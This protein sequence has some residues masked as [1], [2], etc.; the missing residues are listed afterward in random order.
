MTL[1]RDALLGK[2]DD[3]IVSFTSSIDEDRLIVNEV[4]EV[5]IAHVHHLRSEGLIPYEVGDKALKALRELLK[6]SDELFRFKVED[7]HEAVEVYLM[8]ALGVDAGW[9]P[10]G[11]SRN[12]HVAT[13]LRLKTKRL[14]VELIGEMLK[15]REVL[16]KKAC[17][18]LEIPLPLT[19]HLQSAQVSTVA[20]YLTYIE[21]MLSNYTSIIY[22][23]LDVFVDKSPLGAGAIAGTTVPLNRLELARLLGF[24]SLVNN[25]LLATGSRDFICVVASVI[26]SLAVSL[27]RIAEDFI[28]WG[29]PQ[30]NYIEPP[31]T[32]LAT[33]SMMPHKKNLVTMEVLRAWGGEAVGHLAA[34]LSVVKAVPSGYNLDLQEVTKHLLKLILNTIEAL[35]IVRDFVEGTEFK[36][37]TLRNEVYKYPIT[38]TD[39]AEFISVKYGKPYREVHRELALLM[40]ELGEFDMNKVC[41]ELSRRLGISLE[42]LHRAITPENVL[43]AR[44]V[45][46][47]PNPELMLETIRNFKAVL[48]SDYDRYAALISR[49]VIPNEY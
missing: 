20:H 4:I 7:V 24:N 38:I 30:F 19:T 3:K 27:S 2:S 11:R 46:G 6:N 10:L 29:T 8:N 40:K 42:E 14:V 41:N 13:A 18:Y 5:L 31:T 21:E 12:D 1:Y 37:E 44:R 17:S 9:I 33:S 39:L 32:H 15:F 28:I 26:T 45:V 34:I 47:S 43:K 48:N 16:L 35:T 23:V 36:E 25:T 22:A 49:L